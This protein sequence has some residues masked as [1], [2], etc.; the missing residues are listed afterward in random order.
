MLFAEGS[1]YSTSLAFIVSEQNTNE[2][3]GNMNNINY[4]YIDESFVDRIDL[5]N[6]EQKSVEFNLFEKGERVV[7]DSKLKT[8][9]KI[10]IK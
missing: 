10:A 2:Y 4:D 5:F 3:L 7:L 9:L 1:D 8:S 6:Q